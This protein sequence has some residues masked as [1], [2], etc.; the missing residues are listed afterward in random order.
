MRTLT[1]IVITILS[2]TRITIVG[3]EETAPVKPGWVHYRAPIF[4]PGLGGVING[5][6]DVVMVV[7]VDDKGKIIESIALQATRIEFVEA[8]NRVSGD[9]QFEATAS[10]TWP[11]REVLEFNF[12]RSGVVTAISHAEAAKEEFVTTNELKIRTMQWKDLDAEPQKI[13]SAMPKVSKTMLVEYGSKPLLVHFIIDEQG[14]VRV[15]VVSTDNAELAEAVLN[16]VRQ[17]RYSPPL[18]QQ[19]PTAV[20]VTRALTF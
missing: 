13:S 2:V 11:R 17:W 8:I 9:W 5:A 3:A 1:L 6:G 14:R 19:K 18:Y 20:E 12:R 7:T 15:P 4:P 16:A 10:N